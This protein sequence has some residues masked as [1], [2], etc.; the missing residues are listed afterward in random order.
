MKA[1]S[2]RLMNTV[3]DRMAPA[4]VADPEPVERASKELVD[5]WDTDLR[6]R[7]SHDGIHTLMAK[8][9]GEFRDFQHAREES[10]DT[11][12]VRFYTRMRGTAFAI[13]ETLGEL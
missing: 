11:F 1:L 3:A 2:R 10:S 6:D 12:M 4:V 5:R 7:I 8:L 9:P 13:A